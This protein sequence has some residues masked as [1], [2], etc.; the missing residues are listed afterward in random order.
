MP[1]VREMLFKDISI[2]SSGGHFVRRSRRVFAILLEIILRNISVIFEFWQ[3]VKEM[4][5]DISIF[6][7]GGH[8]VQQ[9]RIVCE[10][11]VQGIL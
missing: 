11:L 1:V 7:L 10:I 8:F 2:F 6:S 5:R 9:S 3:V 4:S